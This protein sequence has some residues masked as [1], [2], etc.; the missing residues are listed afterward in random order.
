MMMKFFLLALASCSW[1]LPNAAAQHVDISNPSGAI[2]VIAGAPNGFAVR[3]QRAGG[4]PAEQDDF[5]ISFDQKRIRVVAVPRDGQRVDLSVDLPFGVPFSALTRDGTIRI[6]GLVRRAELTTESG[7]LEFAVPW[8]ATHLQVTAPQEPASVSLPPKIRFSRGTE[9][10]EGKKVWYLQ[11]RLDKMD[12]TYGQILAK[13]QTIPKVTLTDLPYPSAAPVKMPWLAPDVLETI[14]SGTKQQQE[15]QKAAAKRGSQPSPATE[16]AGEAATEDG[17]LLIRSE[18]NVVALTV[19][20][21]DENNMPVAGLQ[22]SDFEV[23]ED[24]KPQTVSSVD[25]EEVPFNLA[26]FLDLSGSARQNRAAL[27]EGLRGFIRIARPQDRIAIYVLVNDEFHVISRLTDDRQTLAR[28]L[29]AIAPIAGGSPV[30]DTI[31]LAYAEEMLERPRERNAIIAIT[32]GLDNQIVGIGTESWVNFRKLESAA[33]GMHA[34]IFPILLASPPGEWNEK[35]RE[36]MESLARRTGG[37]LFPAAGPEDLAPVYPQVANALR[38]V[39]S[40][41]YSPKNQD[42]NGAWRKISVRVTKP[43]VSVRTRAGYFAR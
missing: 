32:D 39:Y 30:Y 29:Q 10:V 17:V 12:I 8:K 4:A 19:S 23:L 18:V 35:A 5:N 42:F 41:T 3:A 25:S 34:L 11:D 43:G 40:I 1:L 16:T 6:E 31:V 13:G 15:Q 33:D 28:Q 27:I 38:S 2:T 20:V 14:R 22:P 7:A 37:R 9:T 36:R 24:G 21:T 26:L